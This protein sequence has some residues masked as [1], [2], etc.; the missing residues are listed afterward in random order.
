VRAFPALLLACLALSLF[1]D[2]AGA[3]CKN[4]SL[5]SSKR[6]LSVKAATIVNKGPG[7]VSVVSL[8][9]ELGPRDIFLGDLGYTYT[10]ALVRGS[11]ATIEVC[12]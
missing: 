5:S 2:A 1:P 8:G 6:T 3:A 7:T 11:R 12:R 9:M 4:Y 10:V